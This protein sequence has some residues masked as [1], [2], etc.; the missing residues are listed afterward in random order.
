METRSTQRATYWIEVIMADEIGIAWPTG[1]TLTANVFKPDGTVRETAINLTENATGTLYLGDC[2]TIQ[3]GDIIVCYEGI[4]VLGS[5]E[6]EP[7]I[8]EAGISRDEV[9]RLILAV[10]TGK[11]SGGGTE[12]ITFRDIEDTKN[13]L[14]ITVDNNGNRN[15]IITRDGS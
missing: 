4:T 13:R 3:V 7:V 11:S 9:M 10:L 15:V 5:V 1:L 6:Y 2:A 8:I 14:V 12:T